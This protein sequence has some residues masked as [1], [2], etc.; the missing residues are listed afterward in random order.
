MKN[1]DIKKRIN[2]AMDETHRLNGRINFLTKW[3]VDLTNQRDDL[4]QRLK[5]D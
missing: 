5:K 1:D 2:Q 3:I 4:L